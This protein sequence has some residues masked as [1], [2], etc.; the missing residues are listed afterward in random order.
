[1]LYRGPLRDYINFFLPSMRCVARKRV[2]SRIV[3]TYDEAKTPYAR[4]LLSPHIPEEAKM[5]LRKRYEEL[6]PVAL[7]RTIAMLKKKIFDEI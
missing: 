2:G 7:K 3:K 1:M 4:V 6:N 5:R